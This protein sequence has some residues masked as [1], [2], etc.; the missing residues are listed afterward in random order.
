MKD[1]QQQTCVGNYLRELQKQAISWPKYRTSIKNASLYMHNYAKKYGGQFYFDF[2]KID[3]RNIMAAEG[4]NGQNILIDLDK[5]RIVVTQSAAAAWDQRTFM[6]NV[7]SNG[8]LP[9]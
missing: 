4:Y 7:I 2:H 5:S 3:G 8:K 1:Y 6:L 9:K